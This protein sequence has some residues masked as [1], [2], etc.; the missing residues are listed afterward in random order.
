MAK[1]RDRE[2][3]EIVR[4]YTFDHRRAWC[5]YQAGVK[6]LRVRIKDHGNIRCGPDW[7][8]LGRKGDGF[9]LIKDLVVRPLRRP[10]RDMELPSKKKRI[11][12]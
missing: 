3:R 6:R 4:Y 5:M 1:L 9:R 8:E 11:T 2:G 7:D 10:A 12:R